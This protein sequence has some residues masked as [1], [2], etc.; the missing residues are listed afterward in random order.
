MVQGDYR[1]NWFESNW[2]EIKYDLDFPLLDESFIHP[3]PG[4]IG[5]PQ[6]IVHATSTLSTTHP[7]VPRNLQAGLA[8]IWVHV[9]V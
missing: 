6:L 2:Y 4:G 1:T 7:D 5:T 8:V 9:A 3:S